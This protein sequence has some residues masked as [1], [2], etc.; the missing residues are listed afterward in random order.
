MTK[1]LY[2]YIIYLTKQKGGI[3]MVKIK[4]KKWLA[5][6]NR[7]STE[8]QG[9][10]KA[11]TEN[12]I[13]FKGHA[14]AEERTHCIRCGRELTHPS[15]KYIG[16]GPVCSAKLGVRWPT[17][18]ELTPEQIAEV[19]QRIEKIEWEGWLPKSQIEIIGQYEINKVVQADRGPKGHITLV[20]NQFKIK[21]QYD[22]K[23]V[24]LVK[25]KIPGRRWDPSEKCWWAP[26]RPEV[27]EAIEQVDLNQYGLEIDPQVTKKIAQF[28][29]DYKASY[30]AAADIK[31]EG[32]NPEFELRP[33][34]KA[35]V[36]YAVAKKRT[37][38]A[39]DQGL[40]KTIQA[41]ATVQHEKA[42]PVLV[43]CPAA[44][45]IHWEREFKKWVP[46]VTTYIIQGR[47]NT[48]LPEVD[49]YIINYD[50]LSANQES[51][52]TIP[53]KAVVFDESHY[54]KNSKAIRTKAAKALATKANIRLLLTGTPVTNR[55]KDLISQLEILGQLEQLGG[56][57]GFVNKYC[58]AKRTRFGLDIN[59]ATNLDELNKNLRTN[60]FVRRKKEDVLK[61]LPDKQITVIP[62]DISN[63]A[64]YQAAENDLY[65][66]IKEREG[67][68]KAMA[69][70]MAEALVKMNTLR[71]LVGLGKIEVAKNWIKDFLE[72]GEKLVVFAHHREVIMQLADEFNADVIIG[73]QSDEERQR[74]IDDFQNN[75]NTKIVICS[76]KAA[77]VGI[78][79]TAASN[80]LFVEQS[81]TAADHAQAEDRLHRIGQKNAVNCYYLV[82][83]NTI[84]AYLRGIIEDKAEIF[85]KVTQNLLK[86]K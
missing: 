33:F 72:T 86:N 76:I 9:E 2:Y 5:N 63:K 1:L 51:L 71:R 43:A 22:P 62:V 52:D 3:K 13:L 11:E 21:F 30:E 80:I 54:L 59:G 55:P 67:A 38:I 15:S 46:G 29:Q 17:E 73:G 34:Q 77:G 18:E 74:I 78:T 6:K 32:L 31:V 58:G 69:A 26:V 49:V 35:G 85:K 8:L 24:D 64:E 27:A 70:I 47:K 84:D 41:I 66:W 10:V 75:L 48:Q 53:F 50:I 40:G 25:T 44:V 14:F 7:I 23:M 28:K 42:Y 37:F 4:M 68:G 83:E 12:A 82:D 57:W 60:C 56:F 61:E 19:K 79:L 16:F 20:G 36:K 39:D 45:K 81:W 65:E